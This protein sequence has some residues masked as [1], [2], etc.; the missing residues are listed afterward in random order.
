M[1]HHHAP[2]RTP[3]H[4]RGSRPEHLGP[5]EHDQHEH[6]HR[7]GGFGP[8]GGHGGPR[9]GGRGRGRG[10]GHDTAAPSAE[11]LAGFLAGRLPTDWFT[12]PAAVTVDRDEVVVIGELAAPE[13]GDLDEAGRLGADEGRI[14]RFREDTRDE[15]MAIAHEVEQRY[16]RAV[17]WGAG[18]GDTRRLFTHASVP[19]MTRLRQPERLVLDTLV[20]GG[21]ARSRSDALAWCVRLVGENAESWLAELR[22]ALASVEKVRAAGPDT[23]ATG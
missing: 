20:D 6:R 13:Y 16:A 18:I 11:G 14:A 2:G 21:V 19:V 9:G 3:G 22:E 15:R 23:D 17:A 8:R 12:G 1:R 5:A 10:Y 4:V 7:H